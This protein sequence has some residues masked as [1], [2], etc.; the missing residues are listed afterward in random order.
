MVPIVPIHIQS[1]VQVA[2]NKLWLSNR[3]SAAIKITPLN[4]R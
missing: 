4:Q 1:S 2:S 3:Q